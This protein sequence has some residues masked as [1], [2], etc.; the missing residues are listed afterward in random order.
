VKI[1]VENV[2]PVVSQQG[3][4]SVFV[5]VAENLF[6]VSV[7]S[8]SQSLPQ[9][10]CCIALSGSSNRQKDSDGYSPSR[11]AGTESRGEHVHQGAQK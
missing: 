2:P 8:H 1:V 5:G 10:E 9:R 4:G 11:H 3:S 7:P 6:S